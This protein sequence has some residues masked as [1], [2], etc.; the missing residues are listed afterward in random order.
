MTTHFKYENGAFVEDTDNYKKVGKRT[1]ITIYTGGVWIVNDCYFDIKRRK[2]CGEHNNNT[3]E[4]RPS[5]ILSIK[6]IA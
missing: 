5:Q 6:C 2:Y 1:A 4:I 3:V